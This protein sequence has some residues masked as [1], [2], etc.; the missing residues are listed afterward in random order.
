MNR[1]YKIVWSAA[2][3]VWVVVGELAKGKRKNASSQSTNALAGHVSYRC[4]VTPFKKWSWRYSA[5]HAAVISVVA[6]GSAMSMS[7]Y[8]QDPAAGGQG[9]G[10]DNFGGGS[11]GASSL[12][13]AG[14]DG[15]Q[16]FSGTTTIG[17]GGGG[18]AGIDAA[19]AGGAGA[20]SGSVD[21]GA[22][23][24]GG[25]GGASDGADGE[26]GGDGGDD[27]SRAGGGGGGGAGAAGGVGLLNDLPSSSL[28]GGAGGNGGNGGSLT[29]STGLSSGGGGGGGVGGYGFVSTDSDPATLSGFTVQGGDGGAGGNGGR[30]GSNS[31]A[32][33]DGGGGG[34]GG[35]GLLIQGAGVELVV[36]SSVAGGAGGNGG[37]GGDAAAG[38]RLGRGG[39][40]GNGGD[41]L[42]FTQDAAAR[43]E[44]SVTGGSGG[45]GGASGDSGGTPSS[46]GSAGDGGTGGSGV[47]L[48]AGGSVQISGTVS[49]GA[50]G[51]GGENINN[52]NASAGGAG[53]AGLLALNGGIIEVT[54]TGSVTGGDG[55]DGGASLGDDGV[56][57]AGGVG[58]Q[59]SN[60]T[61]TV[62]GS[63]WGGVGADGTE[64]NAIEFTGGTNQL[65]VL[66]GSRGGAVV[67]NGEHDTLTIG[68][69]G[70][71]DVSRFDS[72]SGNFRGFEAFEKIGAGT[73]A[74][75]G[76][77][78]ETTP[79]TVL[80]GTLSIDS[81]SALGTSDSLLTLNGGALAVTADTTV[82]NNVLIGADNGT[83]SVANGV[84]VTASG[85]LSGT[86]TFTKDGAGTLTLSGTN[87]YTGGTTI[88]AGTLI[89]DTT[90]L[91]GDI[92]NNAAL[93]FDQ[94]M[95]GTYAG[96]LSGMGVLTKEGD[97]ELVLS[98]NSST[99]AGTTI[100]SGGLL[101]VNNA[102]GGTVNVT[103]GRLGG[104]GSLGALNV[105]SGGTVAPG[106][107]IGTL[108]VNSD[109][110]LGAGS[111]LEVELNDG[112]NV[113]G[114]NN[115]L[116]NVTGTATIEDG[117]IVHVMPVA[118]S[119]SNYAAGTTYTILEA[120]TLDVQGTQR[121]NI[122][123]DY[124][125]LS[126][127]LGQVGNALTLTSNLDNALGQTFALAGMSRNQR[128]TAT[129]VFTQGA[130]KAVFDQVLNMSERQAFAAMDAL[131]GEVHASARTVLLD[132][133]SQVR[134]T[135]LQRARSTERS[136]GQGVWFE[137]LGGRMNLDGN[138]NA[139]ALDSDE[140]GL[141]LG[142]DKRLNNGW[143]VG[144]FGGASYSDFD[145]NDRTSSGE[146]DNY[147]FGIYAGQNWDQLS[148]NLGLGYTR[149]Q[150]ETKRGE[151]LGQTLRDD[152]DTDSLQAFAELGYRIERQGYW[153]QPFANIAWVNLRNEAS[154]ER[155]GSAALRI[156]AHD[157]ATG[158]STL[159][160]RSGTDIS[161]GGT[162][163]NL[164]GSLGWK[165]GFGD[166]EPD[167]RHAFFEGG[168]SFTI[169]GA[170]LARNA[171]EV[172]VGAAFQVT[173]ESTLSVSYQGEFAS[174]ARDQGVRLNWGVRF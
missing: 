145:V 45:N 35:L 40:G 18:G 158:S 88:S 7:A 36:D 62:A 20:E 144:L 56:G 48:E 106:N 64:A 53:G 22:G 5:L 1:M 160:L 143:R 74:L 133:A 166:L 102:L 50:G 95:Y 134:S 44:G 122:D 60:L 152:Y 104:S 78:A 139:A 94:G 126:F 93:T 127:V 39:D 26:D 136:E 54:A 10:R 116:V 132:S 49:G 16:G 147:H 25:A 154:E 30:G 149:S 129:G 72:V 92:V 46:S 38:Y 103:G 151:V 114:V 105:A 91:Q 3:Q 9:G 174:N 14:G 157:T 79:W 66:G 130:G 6:L 23:G 58:I 70:E 63:V 75:V 111:T 33:H 90:T 4:D 98:G 167:S 55:G 108:N 115:D 34:G 37:R 159:G 118:G 69:T 140:Q 109:F 15:D 107:S 165:H 28:A 169:H 89:G 162:T 117:A 2:R 73:M 51:D 155:G 100:L 76:S 120:G 65:I 125:Y 86:G 42:I 24:A 173:P 41:G 21:D 96:A 123:F 83:I 135:L 170:P 81:G 19:G 97:G 131:S 43:I 99:Y 47:V 138:S 52:T 142:I 87:S 163:A 67:A 148:L 101:S 119:G 110:N 11:G 150:L 124:A 112:G 172:E 146:S 12:T 113:A 59:G 32:G 71:F 77:T 161:V 141:L 85:A 153:L 168:S 164:Y 13:G 17:G 80:A 27:N 121:L 137:L 68:V 57:G 82:E 29:A 31:Q 128:S 8:A 156:K 171:A 61:V 84:A